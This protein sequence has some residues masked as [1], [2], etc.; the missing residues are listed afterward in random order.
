MLI[1]FSVLRAEEASS[2]FCPKKDL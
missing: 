1:C 2:L